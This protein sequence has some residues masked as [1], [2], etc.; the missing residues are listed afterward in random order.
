MN[1]KAAPQ[2][3]VKS[4]E[5]VGEWGE[6]EYHHK[7]VC[8]HVEKRKRPAK[9]VK[10]A[11]TWCVVAEE[12]RKELKALSVVPPPIIEEEWD[13]FDDS[14]ADELS[15]ASMRSALANAL[16][17]EQESVE[18]VASYDDEDILRINYVTIFLDY[19]QAQRLV[20]ERTSIVESG[21]GGQ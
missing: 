18:V 13:L 6:V 9:T 10:I 2:K 12:K 4:V 1:R 17:C 16:G 20:A 14:Y 8:G 3:R 15:I 11:C 7:L 21:I 5:R 19:S